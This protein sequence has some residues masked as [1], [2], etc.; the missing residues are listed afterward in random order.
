MVGMNDADQP[1][2]VKGLYQLH[3]SMAASKQALRVRRA[4][5]PTGSS[6]A[7]HAARS[8]RAVHR[9]K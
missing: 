5:V 6:Y 7:I 3:T 9:E 1:Q 2:I 4:S 8:C